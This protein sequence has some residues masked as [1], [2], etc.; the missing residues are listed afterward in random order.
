MARVSHRTSTSW[1]PIFPSDCSSP[2]RPRW[3][4]RKPDC[5]HRTPSSFRPD[6]SCSTREEEI[7]FVF[8]SDCDLPFSLSFI[9]SCFFFLSF[10]PRLSFARPPFFL[11]FFF[12]TSV[13]LQRVHCSAFLQQQQQQQ[14]T[15]NNT[16]AISAD[17]SPCASWATP[18]TECSGKKKQKKRSEIPPI[19]Y[20]AAQANR[21][22]LPRYL[23]MACN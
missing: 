5:F 12:F 10:R 22:G 19:V 2:W 1:W 9:H 6:E 3:R 14:K 16:T 23:L 13:E 17:E 20:H 18:T 4:S 15:T 11:L 21:Y 8:T 7:A